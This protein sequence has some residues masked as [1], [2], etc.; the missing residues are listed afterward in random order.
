MQKH[1]YKKTK[2]ILIFKAI[3][4]NNW[5]RN[6]YYKHFTQNI[7]CMYSIYTKIDITKI[8]ELNLK[9]SQTIIFLIRKLVNSH[10]EFRI[11]TNTKGIVRIYDKLDLYIHILIPKQKHSKIYRIK[12]VKI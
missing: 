1:F 12:T 6:I 5:E 10:K 8:K 3:N 2:E 7:P 9:I 11:A 4:L